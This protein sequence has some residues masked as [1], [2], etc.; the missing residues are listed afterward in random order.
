VG[1]HLYAFRCQ[2]LWDRGGIVDL[3]SPSKTESSPGV[4]MQTFS[5]KKLPGT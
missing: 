1:N 3:V 4:T 2:G 5:A